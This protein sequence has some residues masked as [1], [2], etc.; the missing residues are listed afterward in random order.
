MF[1]IPFCSTKVRIW[2]INLTAIALVYGVLLVVVIRRENTEANVEDKEM[3]VIIYFFL[4]A[5]TSDTANI[6]DAMNQF[7]EMAPYRK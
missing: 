2:A 4:M 6:T 3:S 1:S 7:V 5:T